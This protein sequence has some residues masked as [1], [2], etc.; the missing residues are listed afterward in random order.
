[1]KIYKKS[2]FMQQEVE[3]LGYQ[4]TSNVLKP[5]LKKI[6]AMTHIL[7]PMNS[8]QLKRFIGMVNFYEDIWKKQ[9]HI[10][11]PLTNHAAVTGKKKGPSKK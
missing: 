10:L 8:K 5:Q 6:E 7:P 9:S 1:M 4:L 3:Y 2:F 11:A